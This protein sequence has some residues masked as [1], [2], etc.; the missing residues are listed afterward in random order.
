MASTIET[1]AHPIS[2]HYS[3][4]DPKKMKDHCAMQPTM[5]IVHFMYVSDVTVEHAVNDD[6][7]PALDK[8]PTSASEDVVSSAL[9]RG[10]SSTSLPESARDGVHSCPSEDIPGLSQRES[11]SSVVEDLPDT[12]RTRGSAPSLAEELPSSG[13]SGKALSSAAKDAKTESVSKSE[14]RSQSRSGPETDAGHSGKAEN[15]KS[16]SLSKTVE[17]STAVRSEHHDYSNDDE[18]VATE[19]DSEAKYVSF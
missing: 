6:V 18:S 10:Q 16:V 19:I 4:I 15:V 11:R 14:S 17:K 9:S 13:R 2:A 12:G 7:R 8:Q 3:F 1:V 5:I